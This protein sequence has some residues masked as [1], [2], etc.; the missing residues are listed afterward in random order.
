VD[1]R[2]IWSRHL[3]RTD[4]ISHGFDILAL[5]LTETSAV[6]FLVVA[7]PDS[8]RV[9]MTAVLQIVP[10][11]YASRWRADWPSGFPVV[12]EAERKIQREQG[13]QVLHWFQAR[14]TEID[15]KDKTIRATTMESYAPRD[16]NGKE[17]A[18][19]E[20]TFMFY[21]AEGR[22]IN[23]RHSPGKWQLSG[24]GRSVLCKEIRRHGIPDAL[25]PGDYVVGTIRTGSALRSVDCSAMRFEDVNIWSSPGMATYEGGG[26]G[27][28]M[29]L[30]VRATRRPRTNRLHAFGADV[31]HL[32]AADRGPVLDRCES[33]YGADDNLNIH[34]RFGRIVRRADGR[35][36]Y[37]EATYE[38]GD[39]LE[40]RDQ[41]SVGLRRD[42]LVRPPERRPPQPVAALRL[43]TGARARRERLAPDAGQPVPGRARRWQALVGLRQPAQRGRAR[44][45]RA[46][47][48]H[49][50][51]AEV[52]PS[53]NSV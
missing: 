4:S 27:G 36:Y 12:N 41:T 45:L 38:I 22:F 7:G 13:Q 28:N 33:A 20:R 37:M 39:T 30:R 26:A 42:L 21:D 24:H 48:H 1:G 31:F 2:E 52:L 46:R 29:Y 25:R 47:G 40:F 9:R 17:G 19:G 32:A 23:H 53:G 16:A 15:R 35:R 10:E 11:P 34:G 18:S 49:D 14:V 43:A 5:D 50:G 6:D 3:G 51:S 8:P 44:R